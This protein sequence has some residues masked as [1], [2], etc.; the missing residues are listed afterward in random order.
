MRARACTGA[1]GRGNLVVRGLVRPIGHLVQALVDDA[2]TLTHLLQPHQVAVVRISMAGNWNVEVHLAAAGKQGQQ[3]F[4]GSALDSI[5][6][7][8]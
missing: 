8:A 1:P 5:W 3:A 6:T 2:H 7:R 4:L